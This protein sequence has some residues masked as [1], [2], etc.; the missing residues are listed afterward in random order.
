MHT[1]VISCTIMHGYTFLIDY[2]CVPN[3]LSN[4]EMRHSIGFLQCQW[5]CW[6]MER[7]HFLNYNA[8]SKQCELGFSQCVS[9]WS[10]LG[11]WMNVY[12]ATRHACLHWRSDQP[13]GLMPVGKYDGGGIYIARVVVGQALVIGK[14]IVGTGMIND[15]HENTAATLQYD[16]TIG[17]ELLVVDPICP[18][19]WVQYTPH[20]EIPS[21]AVLGGH[22]ADGSPTYVVKVHHVRIGN[23]NTVP[24]Y[25]SPKSGMAHFLLARKHQLIWWF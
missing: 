12:G 19:S 20:T 11:V 10:A 7:C 15:S 9:L 3:T 24:S 8:S 1:L 17:H 4:L 13:T 21:L 23:T 14:F 6:K 16:E 5:R 25:Y 22:L 18:L 2:K